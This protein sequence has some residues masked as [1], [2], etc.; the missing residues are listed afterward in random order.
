M[1]KLCIEWLV[2][3][4]KPLEEYRR[5]LSVDVEYIDEVTRQFGVRRKEL[6]G[7]KLTVNNFLDLDAIS[8]LSTAGIR[9]ASERAAAT[10]SAAVVKPRTAPLDVQ[11][12]CQPLKKS[13]SFDKI[14]DFQFC[15]D[16]D[17]DHSAD[18]DFEQGRAFNENIRNKSETETSFASDGRKRAASELSAKSTF[19]NAVNKS[20]LQFE[21]FQFDSNDINSN[22]DDNYRCANEISEDDQLN[23]E[24]KMVGEFKIST[25][26][27]FRTTT[28]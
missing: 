11:L 2:D 19:G 21:R 24:P 5:L 28:V 26:D 27:K 4:K 23:L 7:E 20:P 16:E 10:T 13:I 3:V 17:F 6:A 14:Y 8:T 15:P 22:P 9:T 12:H 25:I 1:I 18:D